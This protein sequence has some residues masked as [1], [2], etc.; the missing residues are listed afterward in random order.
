M[1][2][3][4]SWLIIVLLLCAPTLHADPQRDTTSGIGLALGSGG[5]GGL[6][7]I[8]MLQVFDDLSLKPERIVGSSIGAVIG[9][10]YAAGLSAEAI[11]D[12]FD[13]F[14]GSSL[15]ALTRLARQTEKPGL[16]ELVKLDLANGGLLDSAGFL[17]FLATHIEARTF[18]DL[19]IPLEVVAT[20]Y[21]S[22]EVIVLK[23]GPL[24]PAIAASMAVPGLFAAEA[25]HDRLLID[26]GLSNPLPYD[27]LI[28]RHDIVVAIDVSNTGSRRED[29]HP[30]VLDA[31]F[32]AF[33]LMQQSIIRTRLQ[34]GLPDIYIRPDTRG[35]RLLHFNRIEEI[36]A[37][38]EPAA[39]ELRQQLSTRLSLQPDDH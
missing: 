18:E 8:A 33:K 27:L 21:D 23:E 11:H 5:A 35:V 15:D 13:D 39:V 14:G 2:I 38:A 20:D 22:G 29:S 12:I 19:A 7:H 32:N 6:A 37:Q 34:G 3:L 9:V 1:K 28:N 31:L 26:G 36:L 4:H 17:D 10:L 16:V 25:Y 24:F 30:H